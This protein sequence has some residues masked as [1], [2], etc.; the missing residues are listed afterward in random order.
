MKNRSNIISIA[1]L[2]IVIMAGLAYWYFVFNKS[3]NADPVTIDTGDDTANGFM[4]LNGDPSITPDFG[5]GNDDI[6]AT[7]ETNSATPTSATIPTLR[8]LSN[9]PVGGYGALTTATTTIIRWVDRGRGNIFEVNTLKNDVVTLS[10]TVL[11]RVYDS[12]WN[13]NLTAFIGTLI[14]SDSSK[15]TTL[16]AELQK[17]TIPTSTTPFSLKGKNISDSLIG[18]AVSPNGNQ[19][20]LMI[21]ENEKG[22]GYTANFDGSRMTRIF[23]T[24]MTE[25]NVEWP[26]TNTIAITTKGISSQPGFLYF[27]NPKT[28]V[29]KKI[30]GPVYGL[31]TRTSHD[32]KYV[33]VSASGSNNDVL[34]GIYNVT[35]SANTDAVVRTLADKCSW[36]NFYKKLV[37]CAVPSKPTSGVYPDAWY[38]GTLSLVDKIWQI[39]A[40]T[41]EVNLISSIVDESDRVIDAFNLGTDNKDQFLF[42]VN[43]NDLSL[44]SL[45]LVASQ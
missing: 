9:T 19:I 18:Y 12:I 30:L 28:G 2:L 10:N 15:T 16:Y 33:I 6:R 27:V 5:T 32:A 34:T 20:F 13:T 38:R 29:W 40:E 3:D 41:N 8:L 11:P 14:S 17:Q 1:L 21:N 26:E 37:Y 25:V 43:K 35:K 39:D 4:P 22:I 23:D 36:G 7:P 24:P 44:W 45:D 31:S 42:F